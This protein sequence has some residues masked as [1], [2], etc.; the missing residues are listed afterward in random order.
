M[1]SLAKERQEERW[2]RVCEQ[3]AQNRSPAEVSTTQWLHPRTAPVEQK[4][5]D[6]SGRLQRDLHSECRSR[7][8][9]KAPASTSICWT[10]KSVLGC[11]SKT[12]AKP[13]APAERVPCPRSSGQPKALL[14]PAAPG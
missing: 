2:S 12:E 11:N 1:R 9:R 6:K 13:R 4:E 14:E 8:Q 5:E 10:G 7:I 3:T